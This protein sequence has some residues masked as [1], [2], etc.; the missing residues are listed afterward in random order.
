MAMSEFI[1]NLDVTWNCFS[2]KDIDFTLLPKAAEV[3]EVQ[4]P[5]GIERQEQTTFLWFTDTQTGT[6]TKVKKIKYCLN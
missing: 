1:K 4:Q 2:L 3:K 6:S 5:K